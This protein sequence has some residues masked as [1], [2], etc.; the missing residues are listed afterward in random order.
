MTF[1]FFAFFFTEKARVR[2]QMCLLGSID[3]DSYF[4][5]VFSEKKK[6]I[7]VGADQMHTLGSA[8]Q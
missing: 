3:A 1:F 8:W 6:I 7:H 4:V 5:V 2:I